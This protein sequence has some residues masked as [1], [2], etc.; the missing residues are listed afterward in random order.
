MVR[1]RAEG[2]R[3]R[4]KETERAKGGWR[5]FRPGLEVSAGYISQAHRNSDTKQ[6]RNS[7]TTRQ[8]NLPPQYRQTPAYGDENVCGTVHADGHRLPESRPHKLRWPTS[9]P[10]RP[11]RLSY[12]ILT[13]HGTEPRA[14]NTRTSLVRAYIFNRRRHRP[15]CPLLPR[16]RTRRSLPHRPSPHLRTHRK[17]R[18]QMGLQAEESEQ[19]A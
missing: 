18:S 16:R 11:L 7:Y 1:R 8:G 9:R 19:N 3:I 17:S 5:E 6:P 14:S 12:H 13:K 2:L 10:Q 15:Q 4:F